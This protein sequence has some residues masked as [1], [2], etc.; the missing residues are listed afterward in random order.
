MANYTTPVKIDLAPGASSITSTIQLAIEGFV[1]THYTRAKGNVYNSHLFEGNLNSI[2][3]RAIG[4]L[5]ND[6]ILGN[7]VANELMGGPGNDRLEGRREMIYFLEMPA[8]TP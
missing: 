5:G 8:T 3:E 2:I 6:T 4:G 1:L 7:Q